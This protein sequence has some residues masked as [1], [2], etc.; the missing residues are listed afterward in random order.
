MLRRISQ[1]ARQ[2]AT[3][4]IARTPARP[5]APARPAPAAAEAAPEPQAAPTSTPTPTQHENDAFSIAV[6]T[7]ALPH[8]YSHAMDG[9]PIDPQSY[10]PT[11][12]TS[13]FP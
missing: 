13:S 7:G 5:A 3:Q 4:P 6:A 10:D 2:M 11:A 8:T 1:E 12:K 9:S